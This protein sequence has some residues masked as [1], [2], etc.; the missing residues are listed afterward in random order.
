MQLV[1][2]I[3][4]IKGRTI[5]LTQGNYDQEKVYDDSP[6]DVAIKFE[7]HGIK[8]V[9]L[10]DLEGAKKGAPVNYPTLEMIAG[11]TD[12]KVNFSGGLHTDGD[13]NKAFE[14]GAE[15][16]TAATIAVYNKELFSSWL[17]SYGR[18]KLALGA[19]SLSRMIRVGGWQKDTKID[20]FDHIE[21]FYSKG[22]KYLKTTDISKDGALEG[23]S[24][25]LYE[26][27]A[28]KFPD[29]Y[30]FASGGVRHMEDIRKLEDVGVYGVVFGKAFYEGHIILDEIDSFLSK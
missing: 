5:R 7:D 6:L 17:M 28:R 25:D 23:P 8:R 30:I 18:E 19:D 1:P 21:Q 11:H 24:F 22:L 12:L 10:V 20:L 3:T 13:L 4:V 16:V 27:L 15:S 26:E 9:H 2:S 29:L 14:F